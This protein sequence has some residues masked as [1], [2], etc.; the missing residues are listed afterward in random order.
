MHLH[1]LLFACHQCFGACRC[2]LHSNLTI[3]SSSE[4]SLSLHSS[5]FFV[6]ASVS[7]GVILSCRCIALQGC[8]VLDTYA[9]AVCASCKTALLEHEQL[10]LNGALL[11]LAEPTLYCAVACSYVGCAYAGME[12]H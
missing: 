8:F 10:L 2:K 11:A 5:L 9:S 6:A 4:A 12:L 3:S 1:V 7:V